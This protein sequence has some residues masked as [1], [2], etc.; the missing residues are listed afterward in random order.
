MVMDWGVQ[1]DRLLHQRVGKT[2][3]DTQQ[4]QVKQQTQVLFSQTR[5]QPA[6]Q[7]EQRTEECIVAVVVVVGNLQRRMSGKT[8]HGNNNKNNKKLK[9]VDLPFHHVFGGGFRVFL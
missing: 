7:G 2:Q 9:R 1:G 8:M 4:P 5:H 3:C 6:S